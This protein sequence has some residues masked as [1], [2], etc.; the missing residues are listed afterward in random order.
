MV[1]T[2]KTYADPIMTIKLTAYNID[3]ADIIA[4]FEA[5]DVTD[6][7]GNKHAPEEI[8]KAMRSGREPRHDDIRRAIN[9]MIAERE[10]QQGFRYLITVERFEKKL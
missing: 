9:K 4:W 10:E 7:H 2:K 8:S 3:R 5:N 1:R 6:K